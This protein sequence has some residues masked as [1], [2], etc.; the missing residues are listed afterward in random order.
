MLSKYMERKMRESDHETDR[1]LLAASDQEL[2]LHDPYADL[3]RSM[4]YEVLLVEWLR[5]TRGHMLV[6]VRHE[7]AFGFVAIYF[8]DCH[9]CDPIM[10][11]KTDA[12]P[13]RSLQEV[14]DLIDQDISWQPKADLRSFLA[15]LDTEGEWNYYHENPVRVERFFRRAVNI[16]CQE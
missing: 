11:A 14:R 7:N 15:T 10:G 8:G 16:L 6:L 12:E 13:A 2:W 5:P 9:F 3:L 1:A 4:G